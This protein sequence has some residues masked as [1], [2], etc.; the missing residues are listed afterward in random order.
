MT[1]KTN[2]FSTNTTKSLKEV[3]VVEVKKV[4]SN[5]IDLSS[6]LLGVYTEDFEVTDITIAEQAVN[7]LKIVKQTIEMM[8]KERKELTGPILASKTNIDNKFKKIIAPLGKLQVLIETPLTQFQLL[9]RD[10]DRAK[11]AAEAQRDIIMGSIED[12]DDEDEPKHKPKPLKAGSVKSD[13]GTTSLRTKWVAE[14]VD[15]SKLP[16][17]YKLPNQPKLNGMAK[18]HEHNLDIPGVKVEEIPLGVT[19]H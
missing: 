1:K 10:E 11:A 7:D 17:I 15:F 18:L 4:V 13:L 16:D 2:S 8:D 12:V 14:V 9:K 5:S 3:G 6:S 19:S